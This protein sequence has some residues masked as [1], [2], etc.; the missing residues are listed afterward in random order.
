MSKEHYQKM[1]TENITKTY[2]KASDNFKNDIDLEGSVIARKV[3]IADRMEV[4]AERKPF[5]TLKDHKSHVDTK[6]TCRLI[7]PAKG[8]MG[9]VSQQVL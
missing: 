9:I 2:K 1:L 8:E 7:N 6:P 5:I 3:D 4:F